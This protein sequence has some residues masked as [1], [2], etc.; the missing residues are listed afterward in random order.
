MKRTKKFASL[1]G[2]EKTDAE[3]LAKLAEVILLTMLHTDRI[4]VFGARALLSFHCPRFAG[5]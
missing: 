3:K 4:D 2:R 5:G 1:A